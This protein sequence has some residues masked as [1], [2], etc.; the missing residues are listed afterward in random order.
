MDSLGY[1]APWVLAS[2]GIGIAVGHFMSRSR[3]KGQDPEAAERERQ[4]MLQMFVEL[5][6]TVEQMNGDVECHNSQI[7]QRANDVGRLQASGEMET[8]KAALLSH[9]VSLLASNKRLQS[10]LLCAQYRME[11]QAQE[12]DHVRREART[13]ALT[14]VA[15][16]KAFEEKLHVLLSV[17]D[18]HRQSF[19]LLMIDLDHLKRINDAHGH[20]AG[21]LALERLGKSLAQWVREGDFVARY[22]GDEFAILLPK[23]ELE[24]AIELAERLRAKAA[25]QGSG[26]MYRGE[27]VAL[28]V[29]IGLTVS[30]EGDGGETLV[31]RA[32]E[33]LYRSKRLGRNQ[34]QFEE[35]PPHDMLAPLMPGLDLG[36]DGYRSPA[37]V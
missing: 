28:S 35:A 22:G 26:V 10:D 24:T 20:Q 4:N 13:D 33:A 18:R 15:N 5:L 16:R 30:A 31:R 23:T 21:D 12:I 3:G 34:V 27:Q 6:R 37:G 2:V 36:L 17:W 19:A 14:A 1:I 11:E 9:M 29:S 25:T 7:R 8:V 32:D